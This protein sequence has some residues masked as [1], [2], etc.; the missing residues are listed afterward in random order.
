MTVLSRGM[1]GLGRLFGHREKS[2]YFRVL[3]RMEMDWCGDCTYP[4]CGIAKSRTRPGPSAKTG[5]A[6]PRDPAAS[7]R[8]VEGYGRRAR[9]EEKSCR[10]CRVCKSGHRCAPTR[11]LW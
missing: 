6:R 7:C 2:G 1:T 11:L 10:A 8:K 9:S 5:E 3:H 4:R